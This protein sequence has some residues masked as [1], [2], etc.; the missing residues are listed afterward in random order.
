MLFILK[1]SLL[2]LLIWSTGQKYG[3][4]SHMGCNYFHEWLR[5][6]FGQN[7]FHDFCLSH[8]AIFMFAS[9]SKGCGGGGVIKERICSSLTAIRR[10]S[11]IGKQ[12][13]SPLSCFQ[14]LKVGSLSFEGIIILL[15]YFLNCRK[16][17]FY[18]EISKFQY[19]V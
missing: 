3:L 10:A 6:H 16:P 15:I 4:T 5:G 2:P 18:K 7:Y 8:S 9:P 13:Q 12:T 17:L 11:C 14:E 1:L 19:K